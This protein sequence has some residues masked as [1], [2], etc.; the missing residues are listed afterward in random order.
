LNPD[1]SAVF[2]PASNVYEAAAATD[3]VSVAALVPFGFL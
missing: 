2:A 3:C 1:G